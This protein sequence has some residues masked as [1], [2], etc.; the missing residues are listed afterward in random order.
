MTHPSSSA[1]G[2]TLIEVLF[3][4]VLIAVGFLGLQALSI[5]AARMAAGA[6]ARSHAARLASRDLELALQEARSGT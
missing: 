5:G 1:T 3:A 2:F 6:E 4:M